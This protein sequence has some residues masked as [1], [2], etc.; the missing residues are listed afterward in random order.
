MKE[1]SLLQTIKLDISRSFRLVPYERIAFHAILGLSKSEN[2]R[3]ILIRELEKGSHI[4]QSALPVLCSF[5]GLSVQRIFG[6]L[7]NQDITDAEKIYI[8]EYFQKQHDKESIPP[9]ID[10]LKQ[11]DKADPLMI[12][13]AYRALSAMSD[14]S[15]EI[16]NHLLGVTGSDVSPEY[17]SMAAMALSPFRAISTYE[18]LLKSK[19]DEILYAVYRGLYELNKTLAAEQEVQKDDESY[20]YTYQP[21]SENKIVLDIRVLLGKMTIHFDQYSFR[22]KAAF[23]AAMMTCNHRE[24]LIYAMKG[25]TG[26]GELASWT[27]HILHHNIIYMRDPDKLLRNLIALSTE[28]AEQDDLIIATFRRYFSSTKA[29]R[30]FNILRDKMYSYIVVT[31]ET[32]FE[33]YRREFM[34]TEVAERSYPENFQKMRHYILK[35]LNADGRKKI[36]SYLRGEEEGTISMLL[37]DLSG[38]IAFVDETE[39]EDLRCL[40]EILF[41]TDPKSRENSASRIEDIN[42]EKRYL[43]NRIIRLCRIIGELSIHSAASPLVNIYNYLKRYPDTEI[44]KAV[45]HTLA[46]LNYSYLLTEIEIM[47]S[48]GS[49]EDQVHALD[50][51]SVFTE[52]RSLNILYEF[53]MTRCTEDS[54]VVTRAV[55]ILIHREITGNASVNTLLKKIVEASPSEKI[56]GMAILGIGRCGQEP[57]IEYLNKLFVGREKLVPRETIVRSISEVISRGKDFNKRELLRDLHEFLKDPGIQVRIY[58]CLLLLYLGN[59]EALKSIQDMLV[60]R[61]KAIQRDI[62]TILGNL[63][64]L[65]FSFFLISLLREE[66]GII[67]DVMAV[68]H[69]LPPEDLIEVDGFIINIFRKFE[70]PEMDE[71]TPKTPQPLVLEKIREEEKTVLYTELLSGPEHLFSEHVAHQITLNLMAREIFLDAII[72]H[73]GTV[74]F[75]TGTS[76]AAYFAEAENAVQAASDIARNITAHNRIRNPENAISAGILLH[77]ETIRLLNEEWLHVNSLRI[78]PLHY[79]PAMNHVLVDRRTVD[80]VAGQYSF[81]PLP[82][83]ILPDDSIWSDYFILESPLNF[84]RE[85][86]TVIQNIMTEIE[87]KQLLQK[88][89]EEELRRMRTSKKTLSSA[90]MARQIETLGEKL[91][92]ELDELEKYINRRSTDREMIRNVRTMVKNINNLYKVEVSR[93]IIE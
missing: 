91:E 11:N 67:Q 21:D 18:D 16:L 84:T 14:G 27:L 69:K 86:E 70:S 33:T 46:L 1:K 56:R 78:R 29:S 54:P 63:K 48:A 38:S 36:I 32:Y 2:G 49:Q 66:Y 50:L 92:K 31:L 7:L 93:F 4:R 45:V 43:R 75:F 65:E 37:Q 89:V 52:A 88:Q 20:L 47:L 41:D 61:N 10:F 60:I 83:I 8:L 44:A 23:I 30:Q 59:T 22:V 24:F 15:P 76:V 87:K 57:D 81:R 28:T 72:K 12:G 73:R 68:L 77:T 35:H 3:D 71:L 9:L 55:E 80:I 6:E 74:A 17:R 90:N 19:D 5:Q 26:S 62:L 39:M 53:L 25:L 64:S 42:F 79:E 58:A 13:L 82:D 51:V 85:A 40:V 34:I